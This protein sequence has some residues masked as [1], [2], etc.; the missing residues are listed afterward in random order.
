MVPEPGLSASLTHQGGVWLL[1]L[2]GD[3]DYF[4]R[5]SLTDS[6]TN[7]DWGQFSVLLV[8]LEGIGFMDSNGVESL[9]TLR[10]CFMRA[11]QGAAVFALINAARNVR[12]TLD[13]LGGVSHGGRFTIYDDLGQALADLGNPE[14]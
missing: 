11:N 8:N 13:I 6:I 1:V 12:R 4:T 3:Y 2:E 9:L 5:G 14:S 7:T 10:H